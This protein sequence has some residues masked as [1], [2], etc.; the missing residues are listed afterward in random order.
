MKRWTFWTVWALAPIVILALH[1]GA[2]QK[3]VAHDNAGRAVHAALKATD[4]KDW[5]A[6]A[7]A[8]GD[9]IAALPESDHAERNRLTILQA[10]ARIQA[11]ELSEG[12]SQLEALLTQ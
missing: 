9:A 12:Q 8:Y 10:K 7:Q 4:G 6:A 5:A 1:L 2:G 3:L 11:G